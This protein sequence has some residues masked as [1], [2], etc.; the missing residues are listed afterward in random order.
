M[1]PVCRSATGTSVRAKIARFTKNEDGHDQ[2]RPEDGHRSGQEVDAQGL[3]G[4][5]HERWASSGCTWDSGRRAGPEVVRTTSCCSETGSS[6]ARGGRRA[7]QARARRWPGPCRRAAR[8]AAPR[9]RRR[10]LDR[11]AG[12]LDDDG[13]AAQGS[14]SSSSSDPA[15]VDQHDVLDQVAD[16]V[17]EVGGQH[18]RAR[19]LGV[20]GEQPVVEDLPGDGVEAEVGLV[21]EG[22]RGPGGQADDDADGGELAAGELLDALLRRQLRSRRP[23]GRRSPR[24]S[25]GRTARRPRARARP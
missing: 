12:P 6:G 11:A 10:T 25:A 9:G 24:P 5:V 21:E 7:G 22:Q 8:G 15:V 13:A 4:G 16:L 23:V 20:V 17:D 14:A 18:D 2:P 1:P 3:E 19:M